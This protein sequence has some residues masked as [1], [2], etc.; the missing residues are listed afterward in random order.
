M[1][2]SG[3]SKIFDKSDNVQFFLDRA[4]AYLPISTLSILQIPKLT[5]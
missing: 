5:V 2:S 1:D 3:I 4:I